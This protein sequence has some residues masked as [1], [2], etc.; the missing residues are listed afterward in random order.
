VDKLKAMRVFMNVAELG[1]FALAGTKMKISPAATTRSV[2]MLEE[3]LNVRLINRTTRSLS[4]TATGRTYFDGC[5]QI[6]NELDDLDSSVIRT[7][8]DPCGTLR[9]AV[10]TAY[11]AVELGQLLS[12]YRAVHACV[13]FEVDV[14]DALIDLF[15]GTFDLAFF[16]DCGPASSSLVVRPLVSVK[17]VMVASPGYLKLHAEPLQPASLEQHHLLSVKYGR[18]NWTFTSR[19]GTQQLPLRSTLGTSSYIALRAAALASMG[20]ALLPDP[21]VAE[22]I[23]AGKLVRILDQFE[24]DGGAHRIAIAY[25]ERHYLTA[26]VRSFVDFTIAHYRELNASS[27]QSGTSNNVAPFA[28][29]RR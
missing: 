21:L 7:T 19:A 15:D 29:R 16:S 28:P 22:D 18:R 24:I 5:R 4:L 8:Q 27:T 11:A 1:S 10:P 2:A 14:Y 26:R 9:I 13:E 20:I 6:L 25:E 12:A 17:D 23:A 3:Q